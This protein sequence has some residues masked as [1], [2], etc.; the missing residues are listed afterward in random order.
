[1]KLAEKVI[2]VTGAGAGMGR[3]L[4]KQL[5]QRGAQVA[6]LDINAEG[7][8]QTKAQL[9]SD[10]GKIVSYVT[11]MADKDSVN[12]TV[13]QV[14]SDFGMIDGLINNA[15]II[16]PFTRVHKLDQAQIERVMNVNF[17]GPLN[18]IQATLP[19]LLSRPEAH[20]LNVSSMGGFF[21]FPGQV[22]YGASKAALKLLTEGLYVELAETPVSVTVCFPGAVIT[23]IKAN[24]GLGAVSAEAKAKA[25]GTKPEDA[26][27][28][29]LDAIENDR[30]RIFVGN[31]SKLMD[32]FYRLAPITATRLI[33]RKMQKMVSID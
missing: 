21:P 14:I 12:S 33:Q 29:M 20:I 7:L 3:E 23:D 8:Q 2:I 30:P 27:R 10:A 26:A 32:W 16:Q 11:N 4:T 1:M 25:R 9:A 13:E 24:S 15:G 19:I 5:L 18:L 28:Q 31:D 6:G 17:Y 22:I